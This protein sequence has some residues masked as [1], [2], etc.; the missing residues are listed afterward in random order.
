MGVEK[1]NQKGDIMDNE[2][3]ACYG[4]LYLLGYLGN[5]ARFRCANCGLEFSFE[6][7]WDDGEYHPIR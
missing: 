7:D 4:E 6:I 5:L 2:C 3:P 1:R